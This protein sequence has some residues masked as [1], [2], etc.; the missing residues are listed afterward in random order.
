[1]TMIWATASASTNACGGAAHGGDLG[2]LRL[3]LARR[4]FLCVRARTFGG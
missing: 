3:L 2:L 4:L 1:M